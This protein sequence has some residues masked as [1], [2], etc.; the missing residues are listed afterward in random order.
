MKRRAAG[1]LVAATGQHVGTCRRHSVQSCAR[2][3][4][5]VHTRTQLCVAHDLTYPTQRCVL[6]G[7]TTSCLGI[8]HGLRQRVPSLAYC[9]PVG[10]KHVTVPGATGGSLHVDKDCFLFKEHFGLTSSYD[11]MSPV[12]MPR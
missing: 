10:Q 1:V 11:H 5:G 7:K 4:A 12:L 2:A 9:K 8:V 3:R 6:A